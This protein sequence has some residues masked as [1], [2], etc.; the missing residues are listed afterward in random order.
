MGNLTPFV[1]ALPSLDLDADP[2]PRALAPLLD[3]VGSA[4]VVALGEAAHGQAEYYRLHDVALR[5]LV[6]QLGFTVF[7]ME[8]GFSEGLAVDRYVRGLVDGDPLAVA[9]HGMTYQMGQCR[10]IAEQLAWMRAHNES[11]PSPVR[12]LG[13]DPPGG[14]GS[15]APALASL[16]EF[17]RPLDAV[18]CATLESVAAL[19]EAVNAADHHH[20]LGR[21]A[22]FVDDDRDRLTAGLDDLRARLATMAPLYRRDVGDDAVAVASQELEL[23]VWLDRQ[24]RWLHKDP[25][26]AGG[27]VGQ[28]G[29]P[30]TAMPR[31]AGMASTV[32]WQLERSPE[33]RVVLVAA[34]GHV[35]RTPFAAGETAAMPTC[36]SYLADA[37]GDALVSIAV[38]AATGDSVELVPDDAAPHGVRMVAT[39]LPSPEPGSV[40]HAVLQASPAPALLNLRAAQAAG[41]KNPESIRHWASFRGLDLGSAHDGAIVLPFVQL[42][43]R[44]TEPAHAS[45]RG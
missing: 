5:A 13:V 15:M 30:A 26:L 43:E 27:P 39:A 8:S 7:A 41:A 25:Q 28:T 32:L 42:V 10:E 2:D 36:G 29:R 12:Y 19:S 14:C 22:G 33:S 38:T 3:L 40:E 24:W 9:W 6:T 11:A 31:D 17:F 4:R 1:T 21:Y 23:V 35:Q 16:K 37:L 44:P 18:A 20:A 34:N 45:R